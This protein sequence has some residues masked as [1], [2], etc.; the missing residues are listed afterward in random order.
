MDIFEWAEKNP[1]ADYF[2]QHTGYI[3]H[4]QEYMRAKKFGLPNLGMRVSYNGQVIGVV[5]EEE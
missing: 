3:Y 1:N 5:R 4:V 2:D